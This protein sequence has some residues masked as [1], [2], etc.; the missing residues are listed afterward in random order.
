M[1]KKYNRKGKSS[2]K[3]C[4]ECEHCLPIGG[5]NFWCD[6]KVKVV[7]EDYV[8]SEKYFCCGGMFFERR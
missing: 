2:T 8:P 5:G 4:I 7:L 1:K 6:K 3:R